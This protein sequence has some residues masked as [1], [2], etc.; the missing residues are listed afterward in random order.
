MMVTMSRTTSVISLHSAKACNAAVAWTVLLATACLSA[1]TTLRPTQLVVRHTPAEVVQ[2]ATRELVAAGF[3]IA[4][5]DATSGTVIAKR[6]RAPDAHGGD[7]ACTF[8]HGSPAA[9]QASALMTLS[10]TARSVGGGTNIVM[11]P[12]VRTDYSGMAATLP[13]QQANDQDCVSSGA[14]EKRIAD[15]LR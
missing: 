15:A 4:V 1:P 5:S 14:I 10:V 7:I 11:T 2:T 13:G 8:P 12:V 3:E 9:R 6:L